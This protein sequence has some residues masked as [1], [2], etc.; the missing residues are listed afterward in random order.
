V[1]PLRSSGTSILCHMPFE[2][3]PHPGGVGRFHEPGHLSTRGSS[4]PGSAPAA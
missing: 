3:D 1:R 4:S 2:G